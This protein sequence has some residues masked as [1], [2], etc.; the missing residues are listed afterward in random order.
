MNG[1]GEMISI[2][3]DILE[4]GRAKLLYQTYQKKLGRYLTKKELAY[5][6]SSR[7]KALSFAEILAVKEAVF[8]ALEVSWFGLQG[9]KK[10][11]LKAKFPQQ[12]S[13]YFSADLKRKTSKI[14]KIW[15]NVAT[16]KKFVLARALIEKVSRKF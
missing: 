12:F 16:T 9:W 10:I 2:G 3:I 14:K 5:I 11:K 6:H 4:T 15:I 1:L 13:V 7:F 8:K